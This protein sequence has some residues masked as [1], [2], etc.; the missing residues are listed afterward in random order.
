VKR[1]ISILVVQ[2]IFAFTLTGTATGVVAQNS[3]EGSLTVGGTTADIKHAYFDKYKTEFTIILTD[4]PV[5]LDMIPDGLHGLSEQGKVRGLEFTVSRDT[6]KMLSRMR[7]S[8]YFHPAWTRSISIGNGEVSITKFDEKLLVGT[9]KTPSENEYDGHKFSYDISFSV[10]LQKEPIKLTITGK[11][12]APSK[13]YAGYSQAL[14]DGDVE[15]FKKYFPSEQKKMLPKDQKELELGLEF[16]QSTM[17]T[18]I[19]ILSSTITGNKAVLTMA[20]H[21]GVNAADG[22]VTMLLENGEW[23][24]SE[25][26]W[27]LK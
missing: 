25:E 23:K 16:V 17:M 27:K 21:R 12:D 26:S 9:I 15:E 7:K 11:S 14:I 1:L 22:T 24:V 3:V 13:A 20:G 10:S 18:N 6:K 2:V 4:H 8:I 5:A 19:E